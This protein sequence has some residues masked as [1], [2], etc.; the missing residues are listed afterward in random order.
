MYSSMGTSSHAHYSVWEVQQCS[1]FFLNMSCGVFFLIVVLYA[2]CKTKALW[3]GIHFISFH[4][5]N[6]PWYFT[7]ILRGVYSKICEVNLRLVETGL[8]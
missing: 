7:E 4:L 8:I 1:A 5:Q 6:V 2:N 3:W